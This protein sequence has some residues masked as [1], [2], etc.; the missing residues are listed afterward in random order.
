[1]LSKITVNEVKRIASLANEARLARDEMLRPVREED[2]GEP[3]PARGE[4]IPGAGLGFDPLPP[5]HPARKAFNEAITCLPVE[6]Q[7][8]L[9]ALMWIGQGNYA[10][11][12]WERAVAET[13]SIADP[14]LGSLMEQASLHELL[15]KGLYELGLT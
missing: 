8:E 1:M 9:R 2:Y 12:D 14:P 13:S 4:H 10:G 3:I 5:D 11:K 15:M 7:S 6:A